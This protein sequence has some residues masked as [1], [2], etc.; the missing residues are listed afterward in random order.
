[1]RRLIGP[2]AGIVLL[3]A[4]DGCYSLQPLPPETKIEVGS[5]FAFDITD[6][7]RVALG[8]VMGPE[9]AQIE[10]RV[11]GVANEEFDIAVT[12]VGLLRGGE[13]VWKGER[14]H[15]M[16]EYVSRRYQRQFSK[17]RTVVAST[18]GAA[19]VVYLV[20]RSILGAG[21]GDLGKTPSDTAHSQRRPAR[22]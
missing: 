20:T 2:A 5:V 14:I 8:G 1:M 11:A 9:I 3:L 18:V 13:Q 12:R 7:G 15:V 21:T 19:V 22:P 4:T 16:S 6:A 10:G 17:G